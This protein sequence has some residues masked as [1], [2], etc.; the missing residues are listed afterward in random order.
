MS[1]KRASEEVASGGG[2]GGVGGGD[3][4]GGEAAVPMP[5]RAAP[6][7]GLLPEVPDAPP[8]SGCGNGQPSA[9]I[10]GVA[11]EVLAAVAGTSAARSAE[12]TPA[13]HVE[14]RPSDSAAAETEK[15]D[16]VEVGGGAGRGG[17]IDGGPVGLA[18]PARTALALLGGVGGVRSKAA[19]A[20]G[21]PASRMATTWLVLGG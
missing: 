3:D 12:G 1:V 4:D 19:G 13:D 15:H 10:G 8:A 11:D 7:I 14:A 6:L 20:A 17:S 5:M 2:G 16:D 9:T 18:S 21:S